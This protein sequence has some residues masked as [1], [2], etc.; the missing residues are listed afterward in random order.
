MAITEKYH[1]AEPLFF[2]AHNPEKLQ[3][4]RHALT[5][6]NETGLPSRHSDDWKYTDLSRFALDTF[7][8]VQ[9]LD[10]SI[11]LDN[12]ES[13]HPLLINPKSSKQWVFYNGNALKEFSPTL[14]A[15]DRF[16]TPHFETYFKNS[17]E[18]LN[19]A[20]HQEG[21]YLVLPKKSVI[22]DPIYIVH[23]IDSEKMPLMGHPKNVIQVE[24]NCHATLIEIVVNQGKQPAFTNTITNIRLAKN[25]T[26]SHVFLQRSNSFSTQIAHIQVDQAENSC[27]R[28]TAIT[29]GGSVNRASFQ[30]NL[31]GPHAECEFQSLEMANQKT[32]MD[33]HLAINHYQPH[34]ESRTLTRGVVSDHAKAAF[35]GKIVVHKNACKTIASLENK[36]LLLSANAEANTRPQLE[37]YNHDI[38]CSHGATVGHLEPDALF[39]LQSR[40]ISKTEAEQMLVDSFVFPS[41]EALPPDILSYIEALIHGS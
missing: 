6:F 31:N 12:P 39:Y 8:P 22:Q 29:L 35:T 23:V 2:D 33:I 41:L 24:E 19:H 30:I 4:R 14:F 3:A 32:Q 10:K 21:A 5:H 40:G 36:N 38:Q 1:T 7:H 27:Y 25:A 20:F 15:M 13:I 11:H 16:N 17:L 34:C 37:I 26:L 28:G 9:T 18:A